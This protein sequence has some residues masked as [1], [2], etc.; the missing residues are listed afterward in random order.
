L[1]W[2]IKPNVFI[3]D[4]VNILPNNYDIATLLNYLKKINNNVTT[5]LHSH[6]SSDPLP[7]SYQIAYPRL[8]LVLEGE[9][10]MSTGNN[11]N[12][13]EVLVLNKN[14]ALFIP[15]NGW[16]RP[17]WQSKVTTLS[18]IFTSNLIGFSIS[19]W[20]GESFDEVKK[21]NVPIKNTRICEL[22]LSLLNEFTFYGSYNAT[23]LCVLDG[24]ISFIIQT[25]DGKEE[26]KKISLFDTVR[27]YIEK[28][29]QKDINRE[30]VAEHFHVTPSHLSFIFKNQGHTRFT[31][32]LHKIRLE[33]AKHLLQYYDLSVAQ[34]SEQCG[35]CDP[36]YFSRL[37]KKINKCTPREYRVYNASL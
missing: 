22:I 21:I 32:Y 34:I 13:V 37:F 23:Q 17:E 19:S 29:F 8:E 6:C 26:P 35:F 9:L 24:L 7:M 1:F 14:M 20:N 28:N 25:I 5:L 33:R 2:Y 36:N 15:E 4:Q 27:D 3:E 11:K 16:N 10:I 12:Q 31:D 30:S 18:I